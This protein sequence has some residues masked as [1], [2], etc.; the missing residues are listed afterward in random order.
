MGICR[1]RTQLESNWVLNIGCHTI[2]NQYKDAEY[3]WVGTSIVKR[4]SGLWIGSSA[5]D[6]YSVYTK[7]PRLLR[8]VHSGQQTPPFLV[9]LRLEALQPAAS[10]PY[11]VCLNDTARRL[12]KLDFQ[13]LGSSCEGWYSSQWGNY[14]SSVLLPIRSRFHTAI[15]VDWKATCLAL[16]FV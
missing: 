12:R 7:P 3:S 1:L 2:Q 13:M 10:A 4:C 14:Y 15:Q 9:F 8:Q 16:D 5:V 11:S 6:V